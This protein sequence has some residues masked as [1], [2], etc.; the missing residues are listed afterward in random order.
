MQRARQTERVINSYDSDE[1]PPLIAESSGQTL[2]PIAVSGSSL[3][4]RD[5]DGSAT[6]NI[7]NFTITKI[8]DK[9][10]SPFGFEYRCDLEPLWLSSNS[11]TPR[12]K[13]R[14]Y[15]FYLE[16]RMKP[17]VLSGYVIAQTVPQIWRGSLPLENVSRRACIKRRARLG[18]LF[19]GATHSALFLP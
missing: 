11:G 9:R 2:T 18:P 16:H 3:P 17:V 5:E 6:V 12:R 8:I 14:E 7:S 19:P 1:A 15:N 13:Q 4:D 10:P